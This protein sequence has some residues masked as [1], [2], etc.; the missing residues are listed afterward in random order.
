MIPGAGP[1][2]FYIILTML[3]AGYIV[4]VFALADYMRNKPFV[5]KLGYIPSVNAMKVLAADHKQF[6]SASLMLKVQTYFGGLIEKAD[7]QL[8]IPADYPAMSRTIDA[9][10]KLDP[11]NKDGYYFAQ[12]ILTWDVGKSDLA[13]RIL[14]YG[15][16][17]RTWD[18]QLPF[19]AGFNY[20][21]FL[22]DYGNAAKQ[23]RRAAELSGNEMFINLA[24]RYMQRSGNTE[25][26]IA[27]LG[28]MAKGARQDS[29]KKS[30]L[31][32]RGAF[33]EVLKIEKARDA[34]SQRFG[35]LPASLDDLVHGGFLRG[36]PQ[37]PYGGKFFIRNDGSINSTSGFAFGDVKK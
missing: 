8:Q 20:A 22:K 29:M 37:D 10:L 13:N 24:G 12:A 32:R 7:N 4:V 15:M 1:R 36:L 34:F 35:I 9:A 28:M 5:E 33:L 26:A 27:Y 16:K 18:W 19:F 11:Y 21:Y 6:F 31:T 30:L 14:E 2:K 3:V 25:M 17:Y 23:Y